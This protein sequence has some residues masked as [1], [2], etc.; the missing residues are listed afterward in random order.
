MSEMEHHVGKL[1]KVDLQGQTVEEFAEKLFI[2]RGT[3]E[4]PSYNS[5]WLEYLLEEYYEEYFIHGEDLYQ[6][7]E[8]KEQDEY[9]DINEYQ[10]NEDGTISFVTKFYNGGASLSEMIGKGL[11]ELFNK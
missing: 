1:K 2:E 5:T 6:A 9:D 7:I 10:L 11:S 3:A 8:H 4:R